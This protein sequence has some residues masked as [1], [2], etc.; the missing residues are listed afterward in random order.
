MAKIDNKAFNT[1]TAVADKTNVD[2]KKEVLY[3]EYAEK[4]RGLRGGQVRPNYDKSGKRIGESSVLMTSA[5]YDGRNYAF[6]TLF[7][8]KKKGWYGESFNQDEAFEEAMRLGEIFD[9]GEDKVSAIKFGEGSWK[10][11]DILKGR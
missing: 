8:D 3:S 4:A 9:F 1:M 11:P 10:L 6:P 2:I 5:A 7:Y